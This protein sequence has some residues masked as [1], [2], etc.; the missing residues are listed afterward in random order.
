MAVGP[1][2]SVS[3]DFRVAAVCVS[4]CFGDKMTAADSGRYQVYGGE[5]CPAGK[6]P[7]PCSD[8]DKGCGGNGN[9]YSPS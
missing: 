5:T 6:P 4:G 2:P 9:C 3:G 8:K 7:S 1:E